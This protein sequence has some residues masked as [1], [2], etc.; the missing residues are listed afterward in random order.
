MIDPERIQR[1]AAKLGNRNDALEFVRQM[2]CGGKKYPDGGKFFR[3]ELQG[4]SPLMYQPMM[5]VYPD[6]AVP[7]RYYP[8]PNLGDYEY[9]ESTGMIQAMPIQREMSVSAPPTG[10]LAD[11]VSVPV[12]DLFSDEAKARRRLKQRY[13]ESRFNDSAVSDAGAMGAWQIM[14]I[15]LKDYLGRGRGKKGDIN[16]AEYNGR[17]RD[18]VMGIIPRD[19]QEFWSEDDSD[20]NKLA[21]LYA[22]YNWGAGSLRSY[23]RK[24]QKEG[25]S[26]DDPYEWVEG[27]N[28]ET[29][30]YV[31][32]LAF[33]ED[34]D[35]KTGYTTRQF[36][37]AARARGYMAGGGKIHIK[38]ENRGKF[39]ALKKRTGHSASWFKAHGT[40]A[41]KK[42]AVFEL[43]A[44]KWKHGDGGVINTFEEG[45]EE[46]K[47]PWYRL[48]VR[49]PNMTGTATAAATSLRDIPLADSTVGTE[50]GVGMASLWP[51]FGSVGSNVIQD[52]NWLRNPAN[53][54]LAKKLAGTLAVP[55][56]GGSAVEEGVKHYTPYKGVGDFMYNAPVV[57]GT[58][59]SPA[60][61]DRRHGAPAWQQRLTQEALRFAANP[62]YYTPTGLLAN[63]T[64][65]V[66]QRYAED[67][68]TH[69]AD[70]VKRNWEW[71]KD[72]YDFVGRGNTSKFSEP[73]KY[74]DALRMREEQ[75]AKEL[76]RLQTAL[77]DYPKLKLSVWPAKSQVSAPS[78]SIHGMPTAGTYDIPIPGTPVINTVDT[79]FVLENIGTPSSM[80]VN[81]LSRT[82]GE[83]V[84]F[85]FTYFPHQGS[86]SKKYADAAIGKPNR[87][88]SR[89]SDM[90]FNT[91]ESVLDVPEPIGSAF[92]RA[93][94]SVSPL[95]QYKVTGAG[96][97]FLPVSRKSAEQAEMY[98]KVVNDI[99]SKLA[100]RGTTM[101]SLRLY[102]DGMLSGS[103]HDTEMIVPWEYL[104][105]VK[106]DFKF[107]ERGGD[108]GFAINGD[109]PLVP[110]LGKQGGKG[111]LEIQPIRVNSRGEASGDVAWGMFKTMYPER[112]SAEAEKYFTTNI[113]YTEFG[114]TNPNTGRPYTSLELYQE[115]VDGGYQTQHVVNEALGLNKRYFQGYGVPTT[116]EGAATLVKQ[117]R[118]MSILTNPD[119]EVKGMVR[120][121]LDTNAYAAV[122]PNYKH[123]SEFFPNIDFADVEANKE[124]LKTIGIGDE[125]IASDPEMMR[126]LFDAWFMPRTTRVRFVGGVRGKAQ[127]EN[128]LF[129]GNIP[130]NGGNVAGSGNNSVR[131]SYSENPIGNQ[132]GGAWQLFPTYAESM[133][134]VKSLKD[135]NQIF[136]RTEKDYIFTAEEEKIVNKVLQDK[137]KDISTFPHTD[138]ITRRAASDLLSEVRKT[139]V[140][141][142]NRLDQLFQKSSS[143]IGNMERDIAQDLIYEVSKAV[144]IPEIGTA[145]Y[146]KFYQG[147]WRNDMPNARSLRFVDARMD[148]QPF[149][150]GRDMWRYPND[151]SKS[152]AGA[153]DPSVLSPED[154]AVYNIF[155]ADWTFAHPE[156][157]A[158]RAVGAEEIRPEMEVSELR[159][160]LKQ[161]Q[162][163]SEMSEPIYGLLRRYK[164]MPFSSKTVRAAEKETG[165][166]YRRERPGY[167]S[168]SVRVTEPRINGTPER[169]I[170]EKIS[171][172]MPDGLSLKDI[173]EVKWNDRY[174]RYDV[175]TLDG[176]NWE[177]VNK[178]GS[179]WEWMDADLPFALG[180]HLN[181]LHSVYGDNVNSIRQAIQK[182]RAK[183]KK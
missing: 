128:A 131:G 1:L 136:A 140:K 55:L 163:I 110:Q 60:E 18:W 17:I 12:S 145:G 74:I 130:W 75:L 165:L 2:R 180:G 167:Y 107:I 155:S 20:I 106:R 103:A 13:A 64:D 67:F 38:P 158:L 78:G 157:S 33:D 129:G 28:P 90:T 43:N 138:A 133:P 115:F 116:S 19:L 121:A 53:Q 123:G 34:F 50:L 14:P 105:D 56:L 135:I 30:R 41:Q 159:K 156:G 143:P 125:K 31:K 148:R 16:N 42:M 102:K 25:K 151:L 161:I 175:V 96:G 83:G 114:I 146:N 111:N 134:E 32:Y 137:L 142:I 88:N 58:N 99:D 46:E 63:M 92:I 124:F 100:G 52:I 93:G 7:E 70:P 132:Q 8:E 5:P 71:M 183:Q 95:D 104:D 3:T 68:A 152:S 126:N 79:P 72:W 82:A 89:V 11:E 26:I 176:R 174:R 113:P 169:I 141:G 181:R 48:P 86:W 44:K 57:P 24:R 15:T 182:A 51:M 76:G 170:R 81:Y 21:K 10:V 112:F 54:I 61:Y 147:V 150:V 66:A 144:D 139:P 4:E 59:W 22:A 6:V 69:V 166:H 179:K 87:F 168:E 177:V 171:K 149:E 39:T 117:N 162:D 98:T 120:K 62:G 45:G 160:K 80:E 127:A 109:S 84:P 164:N 35:E 65:R 101:G 40:P 23:F 85:E 154:R 97:K 172:T 94:H 9:P 49:V 27:L 178:D 36:E 108:N 91:P 153:F 37:D 118:P 47:V 77:N 173:A 73:L 122:G 119:P 29:R